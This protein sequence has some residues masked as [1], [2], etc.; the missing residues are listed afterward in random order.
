MF[1]FH[2]MFKL[3]SFVF[4]FLLF[5]KFRYN[6]VLFW[7][8]WNLMSYLL[9]CGC[10]LMWCF[11]KTTAWTRTRIDLSSAQVT[12]GNCCASGTQRTSPYAHYPSH[13]H[14]HSITNT[15]TTI[16]GAIERGRRAELK[17]RGRCR[18]TFLVETLDETCCRTQHVALWAIR[19]VCHLKN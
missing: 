17:G 3:F 5:R 11:L 10:G 6:I 19:E 13:A 1:T 9:R 15:S 8:I 7:N 16:G 4:E 14:A 18:A 12:S 2:F